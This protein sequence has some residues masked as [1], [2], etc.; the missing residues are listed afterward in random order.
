MVSVLARCIKS[1]TEDRL[2]C[3]LVIS[4]IGMIHLLGLTTLCLYSLHTVLHS[5]TYLNGIGQHF[6]EPQKL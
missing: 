1:F 4:H 5:D 2:Y 6:Y 3:L